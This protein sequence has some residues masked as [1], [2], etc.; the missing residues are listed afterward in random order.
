MI[1]MGSFK[2]ESK[3]VSHVRNFHNKGSCPIAMVKLDQR[4]ESSLLGSVG[5][6]F[7]YHTL[8]LSVSSALRTSKV[9]GPSKQHHILNNGGIGRHF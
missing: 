8:F 5:E 6:P 2:F 3:P 7:A 1:E 4:T 9:E